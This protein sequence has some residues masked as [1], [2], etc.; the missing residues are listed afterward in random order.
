MGCCP[1]VCNTN[2]RTS[3]YIINSYSIG[4]ISQKYVLN[5][6]ECSKIFFA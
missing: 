4:N 6:K 5:M 3:Y 1:F 2:P